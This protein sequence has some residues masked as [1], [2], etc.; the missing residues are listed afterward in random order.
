MTMG[1]RFDSTRTKA[2]RKHVLSLP[3]SAF[4]LNKDIETGNRAV[5]AEF[6][7]SLFGPDATANPIVYCE[8]YGHWDN[9]CA[10]VA[11]LPTEI[12]GGFGV[13]VYNEMR[14]NQQWAQLTNGHR[15]DTTLRVM[16]GAQCHQTLTLLALGLA[17]QL[18]I[19][20]CDDFNF[21]DAGEHSLNDFA[22]VWALE[23]VL[24]AMDEAEH[25][26]C[27]TLLRLRVTKEQQSVLARLLSRAANLR[28]NLVH[29][30]EVE[31]TIAASVHRHNGVRISGRQVEFIRVSE[32]L[33][34]YPREE[35]E[36]VIDALVAARYQDGDLGPDFDPAPPTPD[37]PKGPKKGSTKQDK[38][39]VT[40]FIIAA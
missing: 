4:V 8:A 23:A 26:T 25:T 10:L 22:D 11:P 30:D 21:P 3:V 7:A 29:H 40:G 38:V 37:P 13:F 19:D 39:K 16:R 20:V 31:E 35:W 1:S 28:A 18:L 15:I 12:G 27:M 5:S 36:N 32:S 34:G 17:D 24:A 9:G 14:S 6:Y 33:L 2:W